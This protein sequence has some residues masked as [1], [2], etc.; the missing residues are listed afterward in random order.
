MV[1]KTT[2]AILVSSV[3][4]CITIV[5]ALLGKTP[6]LLPVVYVVMSGA[7]FLAYAKDK[8]SARQKTWRISE[9]TLHTFSVLGGWPGALVAQEVLRHKTR[10]VSF[11]WAFYLTVIANGAFY[12]WLHFPTGQAFLSQ[13]LSF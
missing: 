9:Q 7:T 1:D 13:L 11:R 2:T 10:K 6:M 4:L 5:S 8:S 3:F 12:V